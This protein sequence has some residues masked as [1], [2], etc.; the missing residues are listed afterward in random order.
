MNPEA[1]V[2]PS[3]HPVKKHCAAGVP[4]QDVEQVIAQKLP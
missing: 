1:I 2:Y 3:P 4:A